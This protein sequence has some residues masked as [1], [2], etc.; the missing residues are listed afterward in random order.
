MNRFVTYI[1]IIC[2]WI[3]F[4]ICFVCW[5]SFVCF[6][7]N[8]IYHFVEHWMRVFNSMTCLHSFR[9]PFIQVELSRWESFLY[10]RW[11]EPKT[12]TRVSSKFWE[13]NETAAWLIY[14]IP[15]LIEVKNG[16]A[17]LLKTASKHS[18]F[19]MNYFFSHFH[20][21]FSCTKFLIGG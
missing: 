1:G 19:S 18:I 10:V 3:V 21:T 14:K 7:A 20:S 4:G 5:N 11:F 17:F 2:T 9:C 15:G 13:R 8:K 16:S 12:D 6:I